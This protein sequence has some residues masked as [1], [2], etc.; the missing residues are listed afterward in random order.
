MRYQRHFLMA[1]AALLTL[2]GSVHAAED[3]TPKTAVASFLTAL[4][5][6]DDKS[7]RA[8]VYI[9]KE[10]QEHVTAMLALLTATTRMQ[11]AA[12]SKF[13]AEGEKTFGASTPAQVE[14]HLQAVADAQEKV[15]GDVA[16]LTITPDAET[17]LGGGIVQLNKVGKKWLVNATAMFN[18]AKLPDA[19]DRARQ[20]LFANRIT[21]V[22]EQM[23]QEII[24]GKYS[25]A[26]DAVKIFWERSAAVRD[27][28]SK[29]PAATQ[30]AT[31]E[32]ASAPGK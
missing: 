29:T 10:H 13:A 16:T 25:T 20:S 6:G 23:T 11:V 21:A 17:K 8:A 9:E 18:I 12:Q 27:E 32:P 4:R 26:D 31:A 5:S 2:F 1:I 7:I 28:L 24:D 14:R 3:S 15:T 19:R 30:P 22:T